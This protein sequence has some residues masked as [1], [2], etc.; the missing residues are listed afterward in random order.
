MNSDVLF[1]CAAAHPVERKK[2]SCSF[3]GLDSFHVLLGLHVTSPL[4]TTI[5]MPTDITGDLLLQMIMILLGP[6]YQFGD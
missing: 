2:Q 5:I 1:V 3:F 6:F 4:P